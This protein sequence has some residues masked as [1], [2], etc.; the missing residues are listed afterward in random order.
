MIEYRIYQLDREGH[1]RS[2]PEIIKC[3]D[4]DAA[5]IEAQRYLNG[6]ALEIW[7]DARRVAFIPADE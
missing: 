7:A 3:E 5:L 4:D 1:I 6:C 2:V